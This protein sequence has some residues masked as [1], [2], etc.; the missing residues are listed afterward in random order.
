MI[1][2]RTASFFFQS[3]TSTKFALFPSLLSVGTPPP[4]PPIRRACR[5]HTTLL[6]DSNVHQRTSITA[7]GSRAAAKFDLC[8]VQVDKGWPLLLLVANYIHKFMQARERGWSSKVKRWGVCWIAAMGRLN[9]YSSWHSSQGS[10]TI[11][12]HLHSDSCVSC[13]IQ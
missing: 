7:F 10:L 12:V 13:L 3:P 5:D 1:N 9:L 2:C 8:E 6:S 4:H 11:S